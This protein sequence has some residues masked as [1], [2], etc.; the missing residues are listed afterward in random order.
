MHTST[1][2][3]SHDPASGKVGVGIVIQE[4]AK[5]GRRGPIIDQ[6]AE[7]YA[8]ISHHSGE[9]VAILRALQSRSRA[10]TWTQE[11]VLTT[12]GCGVRF[13]P[14][15]SATRCPTTRTIGCRLR[16]DRPNPTPAPR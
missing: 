9:A 15:T 10:A 16:S 1:V 5:P 3:A 4:S 8:H 7:A 13:E 6:I 2:D 14:A 11:F 12:N